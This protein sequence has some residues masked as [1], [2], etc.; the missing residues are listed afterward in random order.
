M[1]LK[2]NGKM[3]TAFLSLLLLLSAAHP[4]Y[5]QIPDWYK[6]EL[7][8][9]AGTW[10]TDNSEYMSEQETDDTYGLEWKWGA[11][12]NNLLGEL[13]GM[14]DGKRTGTYWQFFQYWD[15][16]ENTAIVIQVSPEGTIGKGT[17]NLEGKDKTKLVQ[18]F[19]NPDGSGFKYGHI[20]Q[21]F[22]GHQISTSYNV[23]END[24]WT[25]SKTYKWVKQD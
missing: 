1:T 22:D 20:T 13:F 18:T 9:L 25:L 2:I 15:S 12:N 24:G 8:R 21:I 4:A 14:R 5:T 23:S 6:T 10:L 16:Q 7:E 17:L 11:G 19:T 3:K